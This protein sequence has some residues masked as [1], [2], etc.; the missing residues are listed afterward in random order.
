M[1]TIEEG[2]TLEPM[3][4]P[5]EPRLCRIE[6]SLGR[7][8]ICPGADCPMWE[9]ARGAN[10]GDCLFEKL[11]LAGRHDLATWIHDLREQLDTYGQGDD[12][13]RHLFFE[14]LNAGRSD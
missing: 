7:S 13:A 5:P 3:V 14:R 9:R 6:Q 2:R 8:E 12:D 10:S 1:S 11:D 4:T